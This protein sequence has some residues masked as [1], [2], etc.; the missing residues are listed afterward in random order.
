MKK[1]LMLV[2][3]ILLIGCGAK[4]KIELKYTE[5]KLCDSDRILVYEN[6]LI[7]Y[8]LDCEKEVSVIIDDT[9]YTIKDVLKDNKVSVEKLKELGLKITAEEKATDASKFYKEYDNGNSVTMNISNDNP[10][11]YLELDEVINFLKTG[12]GVIYF[13]FPTCPW[14]RNIVPVLFETAKENNVSVINYYNP[15]ETRSS[16]SFSEVMYLLDSY[17][18]TNSDGNK[19]LYVPDVY[20]VKDGKIVGHHLGSADGQK[21]PYTPLTDTQR[22]ELKN[23][24]NDLFNLVK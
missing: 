19:T 11:K 15:K 20:F 17:L 18:Q 22:Q 2:L 7:S 10:I 1:V 16:D 13:G 21:D 4:Q 12:T 24:Y 6:N 14:C 5:T 9:E 23:T 3:C 8:Y